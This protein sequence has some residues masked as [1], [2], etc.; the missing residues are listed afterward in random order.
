MISAFGVDHGNIEK[1]FNP[2]GALKGLRGAGKAGKHAGSTGTPM[3]DQ[4]ASKHGIAASAAGGGKRIA[5]TP[6]KRK[7]GYKAKSFVGRGGGARRA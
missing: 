5:A 2:I 3:F 6:G 7:G 4:L 1:G